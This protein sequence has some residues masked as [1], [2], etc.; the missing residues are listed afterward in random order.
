MVAAV[1]LVTDGAAGT[2]V[3]TVATTQRPR[4]GGTKRAPARKKATPPPTFVERLI[5]ALA[6]GFG[7]HGP[8]V[9]GLLC[10]ALGIVAGMGVYADAAGPAGRGLDDGI[11]TV[12]GWGRL[13]V[14]I[15]LGGARRR[16]RA[17]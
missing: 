6:A 5:G 9:A 16:P 2:V 14:P 12:V 7:S 13:I 8:D 4:G 3:A 10:I 1:C 11:G 15:A 17:R